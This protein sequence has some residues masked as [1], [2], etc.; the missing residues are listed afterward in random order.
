[1]NIAGLVNPAGL[2]PWYDRLRNRSIRQAGVVLVGDS[3]TESFAAGSWAARAPQQLDAL[4]RAQHPTP[5]VFAVPD[6]Y[7]P[8][9]TI[10]GPTPPVTL[11][12]SPNDSSI[13]LAL[14]GV[15][16]TNT[17]YVEWTA[18]CDR[19][20]IWYATAASLA[21]NGIVSIDGVD[22]VTLTGLGASHIDGRRWLSNALSYGSHTVRVR[23][24]GGFSFPVYGA[25]FFA[26]DHDKGVQ[27][28][29][30]ARYGWSTT[31][32]TTGLYQ[33][34]WQ[35]VAG[36]TPGVVVINLGINDWSLGTS[37]STYLANIDAMLG[38][39][40]TQMGSVPHSV[41]LVFPYKPVRNFATSDSEWEAMRAGIIARATGNRA[42]LQ[43]QPPWPDLFPNVANS[44]M[45][46]TDYPLH[47][48]GDGYAVYADLLA[49]ALRLPDTR[50]T[51]PAVT[52]LTAGS[53]VSL[54]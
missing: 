44:L 28:Y 30:G 10:G 43:L 35:A 39:L 26:G 8:T 6:G 7:I 21:G 15:G 50:E 38:E 17:K 3:T 31:D 13:G 52:R 37:S 19:V 41:L 23:G 47:P 18:T 9:R 45:W 40:A 34:H 42:V 11:S 20:A 49:Q 25:Q 36:A 1:M 48:N 46:E 12:G 53:K 5:G 24:A 16:I 54:P 4:L 33:R 51:Q 14:K 29:D 22:Q 27:V 32:A 2:E